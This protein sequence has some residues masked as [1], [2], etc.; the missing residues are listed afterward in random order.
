MAYLASVNRDKYFTQGEFEL[1]R[2]KRGID[3]GYSPNDLVHHPGIVLL[4]NSSTPKE[5][6][7]VFYSKKNLFE[8]SELTDYL[9]EQARL[10]KREKKNRYNSRVCSLLV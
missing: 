2:L 9:Q 1:A 6:I 4:T 8:L 7:L 5:D 10:R 3:S